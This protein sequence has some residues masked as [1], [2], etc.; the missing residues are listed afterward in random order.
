MSLGD[1]DEIV[2]S[3]RNEEGR[4][5]ITEAV[6]CYKAGA[7][8]ACIVSTWI[9]V[10]YDLLSKIRELALSGDAEAQRIVADLNRWQPLIAKNDLGAIKSSLD[11]ERDIVT[12]ANDKF[13][14]FEGMEV[15]ELERLHDDRNRCAHP[16]YLRTE[17]PYTP[18]AELART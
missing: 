5:Y 14:F 8:R 16:T 7:Y 13:G 3:C 2:L 18:S 10:V 15:L 11:L 12:L 4:K 1:L 17:Q 9:A 6:S